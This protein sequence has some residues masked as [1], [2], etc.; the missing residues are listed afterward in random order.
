MSFPRLHE[1]SWLVVPLIGV[2]CVLSPV[3]DLPSRN[4]P[5]SGTGASSPSWPEPGPGDNTD[6]G[7]AAGGAAAGVDDVD[8]LGGS[9][10]TGGLG[11]DGG[12]D[13]VDNLIGGAGADGFEGAED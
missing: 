12:V 7:T 6:G 11:G 10:G 5:G 8:H 2:A 4:P 1:L 9:G 3:E 13:G